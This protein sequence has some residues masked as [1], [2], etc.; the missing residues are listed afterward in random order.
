MRTTRQQCGDA[1][2]IIEDC[3]DDSFVCSLVSAIAP[4]GLPLPP[5]DALGDATLSD[6]G[7]G[8]IVAEAD[9][10]GS[11]FLHDRRIGA[12]RIIAKTD[13]GDFG[14]RG[15]LHFV[16]LLVEWDGDGSSWSWGCE[17]IARAFGESDFDEDAE[18][19]WRT[20]YQYFRQSA[21]SSGECVS[22]RQ[23]G[24]ECRGIRIG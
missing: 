10:D 21:P 11:G 6:H 2:I 7:L 5:F 1:S 9:V 23:E 13:W 24:G 22:I 12:A 18:V 3:T 8:C 14:A 17:E 19:M 15:H 20:L 4:D 16:E